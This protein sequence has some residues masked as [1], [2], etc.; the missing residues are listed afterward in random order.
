[1]RNL[2]PDQYSFSLLTT[3]LHL[4]GRSFVFPNPHKTPINS[5]EF[6]TLFN[7]IHFGS[8]AS[9]NSWKFAR[10]RTCTFITKS[11]ATSTCHLFHLF[12][13]L[14]TSLV[15]KEFSHFK[16]ITNYPP[17]ILEW[18]RVARWHHFGNEKR[19]LGLQGIVQKMR[20]MRTLLL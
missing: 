14:R 12:A 4:T 1:M 15:V 20:D 13:F 11:T 7:A 5:S 10:G 3:F 16:Q 2:R 19:S 18:M 9:F 8:R 17:I 6:C